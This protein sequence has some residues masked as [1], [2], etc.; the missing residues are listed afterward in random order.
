L[1]DYRQTIKNGIL[2]VKGAMTMKW[3]PNSPV[4]SIVEPR[5]SVLD[6]GTDIDMNVEF[7]D[8]DLKTVSGIGNF[9]QHVKTRVLTPKNDRFSYGT[10][11]NIFA[12]TNEQTFANEAESLAHQ[13]VSNYTFDEVTGYF[14]VGQTIESI[15]EIAKEQI[16]GI[17]TLVIYMTC[18]GVE[19]TYAVNVPYPPQF[20]A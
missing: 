8:G 17:S 15:L 13:L 4:F 14:G 12:S 1:V 7:V 3:T 16:E 18:T 5:L 9:A 2:E 20:T 19:G 10:E 6:Y 11:H